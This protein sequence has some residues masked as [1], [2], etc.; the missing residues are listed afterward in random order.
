LSKI[1]SF[2]ILSN[3][4]DLCLNI[5]SN[6]IILP[7][8]MPNSNNIKSFIELVGRKKVDKDKQ[9]AG[10]YC[11]KG[12]NSK[13]NEL[14]YI[15]NVE[16]YVGQT[17]HLGSRIRDHARGHDP[18]TKDFIESLNGNGTVELFVIPNNISLFGMSKK[19]FLF[20]LEQYLIMKIKPTLNKKYLSLPG[21]L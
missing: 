3:H 7:L 15:K 17:K 6:R 4:L 21:P 16:T 2:K 10:C 18:I 11:I 19:E 13:H 5:Y 9:V 8:P 14:T 1:F 12:V 20:L